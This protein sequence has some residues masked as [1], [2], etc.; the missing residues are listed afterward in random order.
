MRTI[1]TALTFVVVVALASDAWAQQRAKR[2]Q[3]TPYDQG[4]V[5]LSL[6]GGFTGSGGELGGGIGYFVVKGLELSV[7]GAV[8]IQS[9]T[10]IGVVGPAARY[11]VWQ[12]PTVHPYI[13]TFYR[14][15]FVGGGQ[16]DLDS[17]GGRLGIITSQDPFYVSAGVVYERFLFCEAGS[18][19]STIAPELSFGISF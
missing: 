8:L 2:A 6:G 4:K 9:D 14:H 15:W 11:I 13:G 12:V 7:N 18:A 5:S 19:C 17:A 1:V 10:T 16:D 3:P